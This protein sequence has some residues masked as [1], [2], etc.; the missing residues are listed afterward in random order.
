MESG[1]LFQNY[2][3]NQDP[4]L[5]SLLPDTVN[6]HFRYDLNKT[7]SSYDKMQPKAAKNNFDLA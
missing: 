1:R 4:H 5:S 3:N 6:P 7:V 2:S